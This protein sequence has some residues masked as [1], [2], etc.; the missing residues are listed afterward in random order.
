MYKNNKSVQ[1]VASSNL[2][3]NRCYLLN[4]EK[5]S[6][7][8]CPTSQGSILLTAPI[9]SANVELLKDHKV[10][11]QYISQPNN[12]SI[13]TPDNEYHVMWKNPI[14]SVVLQLTNAYLERVIESTLELSFQQ[15]RFH[16]IYSI[17]DPLAYS[18][19]T[20]L[21][22]LMLVS[23][24]QDNEIYT[25]SLLNTLT[26]HLAYRHKSLTARTA[27]SA[28]LPKHK[29]SKVVEYIKN[30]LSSQL[31]LDDIAAVS[32]FSAY[33]F[34]RLFKKSTGFT[35]HQFIIHERISLAKQLLK[36]RDQSILQIALSVGYQ[37]PSHFT[38]EFHRQTGCTP[39]EYRN[40]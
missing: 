31:H 16:Q 35:L 26:I 8:I 17:E 10:K 37:C 20:T 28:G 25:Q 40:K 19:L 22:Q 13:Y 27:L 15:V 1:I 12:I 34:A 6:E 21:K 18:I 7:P 5:L 33:H 3:G 38:R 23:N 2:D 32:C 39:S 36:H 4:K 24:E 14:Q 29:L 9:N 11:K 30:N